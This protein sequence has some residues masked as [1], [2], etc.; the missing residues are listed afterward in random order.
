MYIYIRHDIKF[1]LLI[2]PF[3]R[4]LEQFV[5]KTCQDLIFVNNFPRT[6]IKISFQLLNNNGG[7]LATLLNALNLALL[8]S[9]IPIKS[10]ITGVCCMISNDDEFVLDPTNLELKNSRSVHTFA[11]NSQNGLTTAYSTGLYT[12]E[13]YMKCLDACQTACHAIHICPSGRCQT[14]H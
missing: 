12:L 8:D 5:L 11:F 9:G 7:V 4:L 10:T 3:E 13:E 6:M 2:G 14:I 1:N